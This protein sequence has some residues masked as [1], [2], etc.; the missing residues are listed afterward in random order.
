MDPAFKEQITGERGYPSH[1][2]LV[3]FKAE[4]EKEALSFR[5]P[6]ATDRAPG[7]HSRALLKRGDHSHLVVTHVSTLESAYVRT[8]RLGLEGR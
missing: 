1:S 7:Y 2:K 4:G 5:E 6:S 3:S 8:I